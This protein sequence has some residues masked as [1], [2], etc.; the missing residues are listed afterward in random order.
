MTGPQLTIIVIMS[1][2]IYQN[3]ICGVAGLGALELNT[4]GIDIR[5]SHRQSET[6]STVT[7]SDQDSRTSIYQSERSRLLD[8]REHKNNP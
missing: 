2:Y 3:V 7:Y 4:I 6:L 8:W 5:A 1:S